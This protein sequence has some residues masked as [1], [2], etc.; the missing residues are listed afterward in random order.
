MALRRGLGAS[1]PDAAFA[2]ASAVSPVGSPAEGVAFRVDFLARGRAGLLRLPPRSS[3][4]SPPTVSLM[5][6]SIGDARRSG[7]PD[8]GP[9]G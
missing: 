6:G 8:V 9:D 5:G 4:L 2:D 3:P 7:K 1:T